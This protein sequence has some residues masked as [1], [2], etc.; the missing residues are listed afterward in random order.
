MSDVLRVGLVCEGT[1]DR[2]V[3]N[4]AVASLLETRDFTLIQLQPE[5]SPAFGRT[6]TGWAG[7]YRWCRQA[8]EQ[9]GGSLRDNPLF[10]SYD[11]L[12]LHVDADVADQTY[13]SGNIVTTSTDLPCSSPCPPPSDTTDVLRA[14]IL[15]WLGEV[16]V[17]PNTIFCTP[18]KSTEAWVI[19]ALFPTDAVVRLG[20]LECHDSPASLLS[21]KPAN[22][23]LVSSGKKKSHKYQE[24]AEE[25]QGQWTRVR[26]LCS[27]AERFSLDVLQAIL[28]PA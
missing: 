18:S 4:S 28:V 21:A 5:N 12:L 3:I 14:V 1:T 19:A 9:A 13:R 25:I 27:E 26:Q 24:R 20:A 11:L 17:P 22:T 6:G 23:R 7:V 8:A 16:Q 15:R 2:I 10:D